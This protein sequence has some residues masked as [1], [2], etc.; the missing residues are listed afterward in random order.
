[1]ACVYLTSNAI[2]AVPTDDNLGVARIADDRL[3]NHQPS[4]SRFGLWVG[5]LIHP[6]PSFR[7]LATVHG[8]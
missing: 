1:M 5:G 2:L 8:V 3:V 6:S 4:V 7:A